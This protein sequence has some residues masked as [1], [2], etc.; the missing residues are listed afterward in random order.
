MLVAVENI[1]PRV[2]YIFEHLLGQLVYSPIVFTNNQA[3]FLN[4]NGPKISYGYAAIADELFF[5]A[6]HLLFETTIDTEKYGNYESINQFSINSKHFNNVDVFAA[7]FYLITRY[8]EY[9]QPQTIE[10]LGRFQYKN[11]LLYQSGLLQKPIIDFWL[12]D[13]KR[14]IQNKYPNLPLKENKFCFIPSID[15]DSLYY[16]KHKPVLRQYA[17]LVKDL[18]LLKIDNIKLRLKVLFNK[19]PDPFYNIQTIELA[20][21]ELPNP[22]IYFYHTANYKWPDNNINWYKQVVAASTKKLSK[23][24]MV[25]LHPSYASNFNEQLLHNEIKTLEQTMTLKVDVARQHYIII[26]WPITYNAYI[27]QGLQHDYTMGYSNA[28]GFRAG[29]SRP[30]LW[31]NLQLEKVM[32]LTI[33]PFCIMDHVHQQN[34][35]T[36][37]GKMIAEWQ[38]IISQLHACNGQLISVW[39]NHS[40]SNLPAYSGWNSLYQQFINLTK[41]KQQ[42]PS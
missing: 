23:I 8:E 37:A 35:K 3:Y 40:L 14:E 26:N 34:Y 18:G 16:I 41:Q 28:N 27:K 25:G 13:I 33:H 32:P 22:C 11:S 6:H 15:V 39:H 12:M 31:Y 17:A 20:H 21:K 10:N 19:L 5:E 9:N 38:N 29:T 2:A 24:G 7:S 36:E 1:T 30:F 4:H 42:L